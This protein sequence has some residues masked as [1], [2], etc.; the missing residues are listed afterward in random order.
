MG[1]CSVVEASKTDNSST[2]STLG[3]IFS[4]SISLARCGHGLRLE[5][6]LLTTARSRTAIS[7][8]VIGSCPHY[9]W[10]C[11][12]AESK[13]NVSSE[14][15]ASWTLFGPSKKQTLNRPHVIALN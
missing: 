8:V 5:Y 10:L 2:L 6:I 13:P 9:L 7:T 14:N 12:P 11:F 3:S 1:G 15:V 4:K